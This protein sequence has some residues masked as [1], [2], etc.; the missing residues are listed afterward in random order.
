ME[1]GSLFDIV[2]IFI[3]L[4]LLLSPDQHVFADETMTNIMSTY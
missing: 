3:K 1:M 4:W 2:G